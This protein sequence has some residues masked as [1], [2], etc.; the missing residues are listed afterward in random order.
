MP[1]WHAQVG[2]AGV[3]LRSTGQFQSVAVGQG[4]TRVEFSFTP[5]YGDAA[6]LASLAGLV[7]ILST[8]AV[9]RWRR[10]R[11]RRQP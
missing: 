8:F 5:P 1:G 3:T 11:H 9:E 10:G 6:L 2:S 4:T 7:Y